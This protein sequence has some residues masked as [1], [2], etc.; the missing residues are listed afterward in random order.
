MKSSIQSPLLVEN[1]TTERDNVGLTNDL[2]EFAVMTYRST[3]DVTTTGATPKTIWTSDD[4]PK[5]SAWDLSLV[6]L[7]AAT[8]GNVGAYRFVIRLKRALAGA[9]LLTAVSPVADYED[10][11]AWAV[12]VAALGNGVTVT[13]AGDA[14]RTVNWSAF[15]EI[16]EAAQ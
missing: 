14:G 11:P 12:A 8:D 9:V 3:F 7:A 5:N 2:R 1:R 13:V 6:V 10:V 4:M 15:V 16:A